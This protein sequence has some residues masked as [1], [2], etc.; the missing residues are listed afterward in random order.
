MHYIH[1]THTRTTPHTHTHT[2]TPLT[3]TTYFNAIWPNRNK[4]SAVSKVLQLLL[5]A[6]S[7]PLSHQ[8]VAAILQ[9]CP[10]QL[11]TFLKLLQPHL[12][13]RPLDTWVTCLQ[14]FL[15]VGLQSTLPSFLF[16]LLP[17][18]MGIWA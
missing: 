8:L 9:A 6:Y 11:H 14:F 13:P 5:T 15:K 1:H 16:Q 17:R 10:H 18:L 3:S 2:H 7:T 12:A 4:N